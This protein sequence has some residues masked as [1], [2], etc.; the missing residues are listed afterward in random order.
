VQSAGDALSVPFD[1]MR[2]CGWPGWIPKR[3]TAN[4]PRPDRIC[5]AIAS[6]AKRE[7]CVAWHRPLNDTLAA[8]CAAFPR[9]RPN[10]AARGVMSSAVELELPINAEATFQV[11]SDRPR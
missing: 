10:A 2:T 5:L 4:L 9:V 3:S 11:L 6:S 8:W 7:K 1:Q